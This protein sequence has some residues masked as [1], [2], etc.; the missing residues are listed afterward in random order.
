MNDSDEKPKLL[1]SYLLNEPITD[2]R[3]ASDEE[4]KLLR[5]YLLGELNEQQKEAVEERLM[6]DDDSFKE[7]L[8]VEDDLIDDYVQGELSADE[9]KR[10]EAT[11]LLTPRGRQQV[12]LTRRLREYAPVLR[13]EQESPPPVAPSKPKWWQQWFASPALRLATSFVVLLVVGVGVWRIAI[14]QSDIDKGLAAL[15][16]AYSSQRPFEARISEFDYAQYSV[17][18]G[19]ESKAVDNL[20]KKLAETYLLAAAQNHSSAES[21]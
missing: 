6:M 15:K 19:N 21:D 10:F 7:S 1:R 9:R 18:R 13:P 4:Q 5:S 16:K 17:T 20:S 12:E 14:Y 11:I 8:L 2:Y 3:Q